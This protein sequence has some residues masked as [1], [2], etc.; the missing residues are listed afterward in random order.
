MKRHTSWNRLFPERTEVYDSRVDCTYRILYNILTMPA[1][2]DRF[3]P[4]RFEMI[5]CTAMHGHIDD[6][7]S[8]TYFL[9]TSWII[10]SECHFSCIDMRLYSDGY[11]TGCSLFWPPAVYGGRLIQVRC[12]GIQLKLLRAV[13]TMD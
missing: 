8:F 4:G 11:R 9:L 13:W 7:Q 1:S 12:M 3:K 5:Y 10:F 6:F 2:A